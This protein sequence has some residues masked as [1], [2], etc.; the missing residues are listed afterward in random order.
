MQCLHSAPHS[1]WPLFRQSA[2]LA[3][4]GW[5]ADD[6]SWRC[7][8][9]VGPSP[10]HVLSPSPYLG[11]DCKAGSLHASLRAAER[12]QTPGIESLCSPA[13]RDCVPLCF[14]TFTHS[15]ACLSC[16]SVHMPFMSLQE[17]PFPLLPPF[18]KVSLISHC[19]GAEP[20]SHCIAYQ[21]VD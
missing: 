14:S 21:K 13:S 15:S 1:M 16:I 9:M 5:H 6:V 12:S 17:G 11:D 3:M 7:G 19:S 4:P 10:S 8:W 18:H 20:I 2:G